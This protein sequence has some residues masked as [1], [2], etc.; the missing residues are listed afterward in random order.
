MNKTFLFLG[1]GSPEN[2]GCEAITKGTIEALNYIFD[3]VNIIDSFYD[4]EN[5]YNE[6]DHGTVSVKPVK[7]PK[8]WSVKWI[9]LQIAFR[10][11]YKLISYL[12]FYRHKNDIAK[13]SAVLSLGGDNYSF[14]YGKPDRF[15]AMG[16][17]VKKINTPFVIWGASIGP[18]TSNPKFEKRIAEHFNLDVDLILVRE[19]ESKDYLASIDVTKNVVLV[20]DP[21]FL[22]HPQKCSLPFDLPTEF[23][24]INFSDLMA[25]Y[26]TNSDMNK[27]IDICVQTIDSLVS[28]FGYNLVFVPHVKSDYDF[29]HKILAKA[30]QAN[31]VYLLERGLCADEM[32]WV[33]SK[34]I[35]N[36][37]CRTH[38]TI[39]SLSSSVPTISLGYSIKAKG[40][41]KQ[42]FN[43]Q[44]YLIYKE[45]ITSSAII[46]CAKR[47]LAEQNE[48]REILKVK[49][50][51]IKEEAKRASVLLNNIL[52]R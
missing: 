26:V 16:K 42:M 6:I 3:D 28:T 32:K 31:R 30:K 11:S 21:A 27:W 4:Y 12:L 43:N 46:S 15:I 38:S 49:N 45:E 10:F 7:Y 24:C 19:S 51:Y 2:G 14:D 35:C 17:Y 22:M 1:N 25:C 39:A 23:I 48:I 18:F 44:K 33:I 34:S 52:N 9:I 50:L 8:R 40:I 41:N 20:A 37:A 5:K 29:A 13:S 47:V 36:I